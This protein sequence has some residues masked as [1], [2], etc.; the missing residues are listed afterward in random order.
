[1]LLGKCSVVSLRTDEIQSFD[2]KLNVVKACKQ[3]KPNFY[4]NDDLPPEKQTILFVLRQAR[5]KF[6][7]KID[8][9][10]ST[11]GKIYVYLKDEGEA[12]SNN[13]RKLV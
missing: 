13:G 8:G 2:T 3:I 5:R 1:M 4:A 12:A 11:G 10:S 9:C 6:P 7:A